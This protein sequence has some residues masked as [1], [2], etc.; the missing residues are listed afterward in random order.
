MKLKQL[1]SG[2]YFFNYLYSGKIAE[3]KYVA[4]HTV[5]GGVTTMRV[6]TYSAIEEY[7][8]QD[9]KEGL[10]G[11]FFFD[12][13]KDIFGVEN[14]DIA[15]WDGHGRIS[16]FA[17]DLKFSYIRVMDSEYNPMLPTYNAHYE[18]DGEDHSNDFEFQ[19]FGGYNLAIQKLDINKKP[20]ENDTYI[21]PQYIIPEV[22]DEEIIDFSLDIELGEVYTNTVSSDFDWEN[23]K[24]IIVLT[25]A[26]YNETAQIWVKGGFHT[27]ASFCYFVASAN[28]HDSEPYPESMTINTQIGNEDVLDFNY[29]GI[30]L[31][32][33]EQQYMLV[34]NVFYEFLYYLVHLHKFHVHS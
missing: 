8:F 1:Y 17:L 28:L 26:Q 16:Y 31:R 20:L 3:N 10:F 12:L 18:S 29:Y 15:I 4:R 14:Y 27:D 34:H 30:N 9:L 2:S 21:R 32:N 33:D 22:D 19:G 24:I 7:N 11:G 5:Y 25:E 13:V 6:Y 23:R